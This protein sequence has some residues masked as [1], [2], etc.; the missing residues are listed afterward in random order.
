MWS[1][2]ERVGGR[3]GLL[4]ETDIVIKPVLEIRVASPPPNHP[5]HLW[6]GRDCISAYKRIKAK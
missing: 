4:S 6:L 3:E 5:L 1:E 2:R